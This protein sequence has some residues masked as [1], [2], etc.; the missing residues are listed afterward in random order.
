MEA[1]IEVFE[2]Y[3]D[4]LDGL[5]DLSSIDVIWYGHLSKGALKVIPMGSSELKGVF[6][7]RSPDRPN[8][9]LVSTVELLSVDLE[10]GE[11]GVAGLDAIDGSPVL[12]IKHPVRGEV[13]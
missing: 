8:P 7:T 6:A 5:A 11:V 12:D 10:R 1:T 4:G 2:G 13:S 3:R 9:I